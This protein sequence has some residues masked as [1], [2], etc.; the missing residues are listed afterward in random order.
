MIINE[1][2]FSHKNFIKNLNTPELLAEWE[3]VKAQII[4][5]PTHSGERFRVDDFTVYIISFGEKNLK[6]SYIFE[7]NEKF[8]L[9][10]IVF[11]GTFSV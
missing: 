3:E 2:S 7:P 11:N 8:D 6:I 4:K 10:F 5:D 1:D 9:S